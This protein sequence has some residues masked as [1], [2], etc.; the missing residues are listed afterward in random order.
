MS[1]EGIPS[2]IISDGEGEFLHELCENVCKQLNI[3]KGVTTPYHPSSYGQVVRVNSNTKN[4][5][6]Y[7]DR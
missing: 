3:D 4:P 2:E 6:D 1:K 7:G 5:E